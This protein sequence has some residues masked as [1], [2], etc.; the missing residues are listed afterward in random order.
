MEEGILPV[1]A[2]AAWRS[3]ERDELAVEMLSYNL[4]DAIRPMGLLG[5]LDIGE[6]PDRGLSLTDFGADSARAI[7]WHRARAPRDSIG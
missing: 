5:M 1:L 4:W 7:L 2:E 3:T 6:W